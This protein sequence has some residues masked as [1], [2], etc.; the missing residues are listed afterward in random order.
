M[1]GP[2][3]ARPNF[4]RL[5][6][7][8]LPCLT[9][10]SACSIRRSYPKGPLTDRIKSFVVVLDKDYR[11]DDVEDVRKALLMVKGVLS[12]EASVRDLNDFANRERIFWEMHNALL[13]AM[14]KLRNRDGA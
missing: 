2:F 7:L 3:F 10:L 13:D 9:I 11:V 14:Q 1:R 8:S 6:K 12:V 4:L 5:H